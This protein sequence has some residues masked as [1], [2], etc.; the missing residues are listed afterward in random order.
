LRLRTA[1]ALAAA[2]VPLAACGGGMPVA[3]ASAPPEAVELT[4]FAA[5]SLGDALTEVKTAYEAAHDDV[6]LLLGFNASSALRTQIAAGAPADVF[7][8][9]DTANPQALADAGLTAG[10]PV[11]FAGNRLAIVVPS[12]N[13]A[14][15]AGPE[16]I[17]RPGVR[18]VAAGEEVPITIY[19][20]RAVSM[21]AELPG[22]PDDFAAR[23]AANVVSRE[24]SVASVLTKIELGE[25]DAGIVYATDAATSREVVTIPMP[26]QASVAA[27]YAG[28][29]VRDSAHPDAAHAFLEWLAGP[30][31][32]A[33]LAEFG[34]ITAP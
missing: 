3:D 30:D 6:S 19:A 13:P 14:S 31:G 16:D 28:V 1:G 26:D 32:Q 20:A 7:L 29:V 33:I 18:V 15:I 34:F 10:P 23:Y 8:S 4:V 21:L 2:L 11:S 25:G 12:E 27:T 22:Y 5:A 24:D 9:A 17:G